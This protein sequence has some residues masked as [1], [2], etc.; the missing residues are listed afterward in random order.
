[1]DTMNA[2]TRSNPR[3]ESGVVLLAVLL[4]G[5]VTGLIVASFMEA[6]GNA[7]HNVKLWNE[8]DEALSIAMSAMEKAKW[9]I[10]EEFHTHFHSAPLPQT[11]HKF[12]WFESFAPSWIG[13]SST[14]NAPQEE[15]FDGGTVTVTIQ[16]VSRT[17][18]AVVDVLLKA[19]AKNG[20]AERTV[21]EVVRY[22]LT[23]SPV[24]DYAYFVNNF[25]WLWGSSITSHGSVRANADFSTKHGPTINGDVYAAANPDLGAAGNVDG[26]WDSWTLSQYYSHAPDQARPG[27][28]PSEAFTGDWPMGYDPETSAYEQVSELPMPYLG[29]LQWYETLAADHGST[30]KVKNKIVVDQVYDGPGPDGLSD[31]PDD[32]MI[33]LEGTES[34]PLVIDGPVVVRG[35]VAIRGV[36]SGQGT[37]YAG[38]NIHIAGPLTYVAPPE[39][40]KPDSEPMEAVADNQDADMVGLA[41]KGNIILGDYTSDTWRSNVNSYIQPSFTAAYD[42]DPSDFDNGYDSDNDP[43][44]GYRFNGDYTA[45]DGSKKI[46]SAGN[47]GDRRYFQSSSDQAFRTLNPTN[48]VE[49]VDAVCYTNHLFGGKTEKIQFN[50]SIIARDEAVIFE[51][52][53]KFAWDIRLGSPLYDTARV[54]FALP[55]TLNVPI[56]MYW[57]EL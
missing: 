1:M 48:D 46:N 26:S 29:D 37:I 6:A 51:N 27:D 2:H 57:R 47:V 21:Q 4:V 15:E 12:D 54:S 30:L 56:T 34:E 9:D 44:N 17:E 52:S 38:R 42:T 7:M 40:D 41:A 53:A 16:E 13:G 20:I 32:G 50:G 24:F 11:Q 55:Q 18:R 45:T 33:V 22:Q 23:T 49:Q 5:L 19:S 3:Q 39:W 14:Y 25:G 43:G 36:I 28:P 8:T 10:Y 31:T 35:D